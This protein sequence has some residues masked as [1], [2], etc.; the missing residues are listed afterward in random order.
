MLEARKIVE[1]YMGENS[2]ASVAQSEDTINQ[3]NKCRALV[4][5]LIHLE[6]KDWPKLQ[7]DLKK[8]HSA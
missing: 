8:L 4:E 3:D 2:Y 1:T 5:K 6:V 7:E